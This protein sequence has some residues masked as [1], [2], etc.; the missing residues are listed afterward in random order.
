MSEYV[1]GKVSII[2]P[3]YKTEMKYINRCIESI[4]GQNYTNYEV[5]LVDDGNENQYAMELDRYKNYSD[6]IKVLHKVNGG[7]SSARNAGID[8]AEGEYVVFVDSDDSMGKGFL[9]KAVKYMEKYN[10]DIVL[11]GYTV[12]E[13]LHIPDCDKIKIYESNLGDI[14][15]FFFTG[16]AGKKTAELRNCLGLVAPWAKMFRR[17]IIGDVRFDERLILSEDTIFNLYC[18]DNAVKVGVVREVFYHYSVMENSI[19]H[20]FRRNAADEI[21]CST[22]AYKEYLEKGNPEFENRQSAFQYR[23]LNQLHSL[24]QYCYCNKEYDG[25]RPIGNIRKFL[26]KYGYSKTDNRDDYFL[27]KG[28]KIRRMLA[29]RNSAVGLY[30]FYKLKR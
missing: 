5:I 9:D 8:K 18:L 22:K 6:K 28:V 26:K 29:K 12:E 10:L 30:L 20:T 3:V 13:S 7:A 15:E 1:D 24:L 14:K 2:V 11:G 25:D 23:M 19:C 17:A 16:F 4:I 21:D 27:T